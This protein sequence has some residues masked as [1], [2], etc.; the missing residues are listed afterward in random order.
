MAVS[1]TD[2]GQIVDDAGDTVVMAFEWPTALPVGA[3]WRSQ[4]RVKPETVDVAATPTAS[5]DG[6][7]VSFT[8]S[9]ATTRSL[10]AGTWWWDAEYEVDGEVFTF[11]RGTVRLRQDVTR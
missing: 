1:T 11:A 3:V 6:T 7:T 8:L 2:V 9:A 10:G 4:W 5:T